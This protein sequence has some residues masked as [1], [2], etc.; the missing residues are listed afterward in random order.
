MTADGSK[1]APP[2]V[3]SVPALPMLDKLVSATP[4]LPF[5]LLPLLVAGGTECEAW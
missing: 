2:L 1:A 3:T 4:L 5:P